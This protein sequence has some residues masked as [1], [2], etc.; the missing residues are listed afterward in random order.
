MAQEVLDQPAKADAA[1]VRERFHRNTVN[2][3]FSPTPLLP[4]QWGAHILRL[5]LALS[6]SEPL[7]RAAA[8][9]PL[10]QGLYTLAA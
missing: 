6:S 4:P 2:S 9:R 3:M 5:E 10:A 1:L 7:G 8:A